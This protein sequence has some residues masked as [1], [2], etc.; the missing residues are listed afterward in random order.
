MIIRDLNARGTCLED[1]TDTMA[2]QHMTKN[3]KRKNWLTLNEEYAYGTPTYKT[4]TGGS[5]RVDM[6]LVPE[7]QLELWTDLKIAESLISI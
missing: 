6:T 3:I 2:G 7:S 5:S 4:F 1:K